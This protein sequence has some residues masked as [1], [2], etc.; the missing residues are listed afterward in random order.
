MSEKT[1]S[2]EQ[3][4]KKV[5]KI[6]S[7]F[8]VLRT[9]L[10]ILIALLIVFVIIGIVSDKPLEAIKTL[11]VGPITTVRRFSNVIELMIP[12]AF[13]GLALSI[14]FTTNRFNLSSESAFFLGA[15]VACLI[16][17]FSPTPPALT[18]I[19]ALI[20]GFVAGAIIGFIPAIC[21]KKF[22]ANVLVVSLMLNYAIGFFVLYLFNYFARDPNSTNLQSYRMP[23]NVNLGKIFKGTKL[24]YGILILFAV[25]VI[26]YLYIYK[27]KGGFTLRTVGSNEHFANY[28]GI[29]VG[30]TVILAQ[31]IG[32]G[33][34]GLGGSVEM[35][36]IYK[37]FMWTAS[38]G[39]GFDGVIIATLARR[40]PKN[41]PL[42]AFFLAYIRVGADILNRTS[43]I[44][45]EI[46]S[47]VQA[48]IILLIAAQA[49]L[50]KW[51]QK[52]IVEVST[53]N[54]VKEE[55]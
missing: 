33:I 11:I 35:L 34:A 47:V 40:N 43:D 10:A 22:G 24:H 53:K 4:H 25:I 20:G 48:A 16:G 3:I 54:I 55:A 14:V 51:K 39:Y 38:P 9:V 1:L 2:S 31:I 17:L 7:R 42:A 36:G 28:S 12:L 46:I 15:M 26:A 29:N 44:P 19:L 5:K 49:F 18:I 21:E 30:K 27:T 8:E 45:A 23:D 41:I 52:Q 50:S 6:E 32:T 13:C 37:T